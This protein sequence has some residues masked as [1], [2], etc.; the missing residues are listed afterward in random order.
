MENKTANK[1]SKIP[2]I[3]FAFF[4]VIILVNICYIYVAKKTW[5]GVT[6]ENSYQKGLTYNDTL[7]QVEKQKELGW[8][9]QIKP[10]ST[11]QNKLE[12]VINV[13]DNKQS[14]IKDAVI[15]INFKRPTQEGFDFAM[16][17]T[18]NIDGINKFSV[19]FPFK[20]QWDAMISISKGKDKL[21]LT[22]RFVIQ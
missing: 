19:V 13:L 17:P 12:L 2:Y 22:R 3:F 4:G 16:S 1:P 18:S 15:Y 8:Q 5:R 11:G 20:G 14:P 21:Y 7:K 9:V 6:T 10:S